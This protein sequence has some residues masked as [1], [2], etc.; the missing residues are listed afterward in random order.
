MVESVEA[1]VVANQLVNARET[2]GLTQDDVSELLNISKARIDSWETGDSIPSV[3]ELWALA[4]LYGR[5]TDYFLLELPSMPKSLSF[6]MKAVNV[7]GELPQSAKKTLIRFEE[8]CRAEYELEKALGTA[9][10]MH[11]K[12]GSAEDPATL[13]LNERFRL[14]L[15]DNPI[16]DMR[17][18]LILQGVRVFILPIPELNPMELSGVS[19]WHEMYGPCILINGK[20]IPGRRIF[21]LAH[22]YAHLLHSDPPAVC[23]YMFD[24]PDERFADLFAK[25]FLMPS[26]SVLGVFQHR[27]YTP[28]NITDR[29]L[30]SIANT[31]SVSLEAMSIRLEEVG[32]VPRGFTR[33][34]VERW[35]KERRY[36][37]R[38]RGPMWKRQLGEE[39]VQ[40]A[41]DAY[42]KGLVSSNKLANYFGVDI[43]ETLN[44]V[45]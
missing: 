15:G 13:A 25:E 22:E 40:L 32:K 45:R 34:N 23:A 44:A 20:N 10:G 38:S 9:R 2:A 41:G 1:R 29:E 19:W 5:S 3:E 43:R 42:R 33:I 27:N 16:R 7:L 24:R 4:D 6:R 37:R 21:T 18:L 26:S 30:G 12:R 36:Y 11:F 17:H 14:R 35:G 31:F 8:L 39:F 28:G